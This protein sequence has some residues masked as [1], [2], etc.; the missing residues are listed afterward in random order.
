MDRSTVEHLRPAGGWSGRPPTPPPAGGLEAE[1]FDGRVVTGGLRLDVG[2]GAG[3]YLP[4]L[5]LPGVA[6]DA[7]AVMLDACRQ[8]VPDALY[9]R[10]DVEHLPFA[11]GSLGGAWSWMTHLHVPRD[12]LPLALW[13][14]HRVL[15]VGSPFELQVLEGDV[16]G[17]RPPRRRGRRPL[18]RRLDAGPAGRR[19]HRGRVRGGGRDR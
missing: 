15:A 8:Q 14:L 11:R 7:S 16:R 6:F 13:D 5:G 18:L 19:G 10:A 1:A 2:C 9:V 12:R 4:H 3:R 17:R